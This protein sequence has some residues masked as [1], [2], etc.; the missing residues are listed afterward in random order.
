MTLLVTLN[1]TKGARERHSGARG[2]GKLYAA[3]SSTT[4]TGANRL[5]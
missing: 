3:G 2:I 1:V 5:K 4:W